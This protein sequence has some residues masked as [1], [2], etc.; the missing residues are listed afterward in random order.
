MRWLGVKGETGPTP[1]LTILVTPRAVASCCDDG[2]HWTVGELLRFDGTSAIAVASITGAERVVDE[3]G[4][5]RL[6][7]FPA[8]YEHRLGLVLGRAVAHEIG[9][10][11]L[12]TN[13]HAQY[14]LMRANIDAR[15]FADLRADSFRLDP[16]ADAYL[17][18]LANRGAL[19]AGPGREAFSYSTQ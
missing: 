2:P 9:H 11:V 14:G 16:A 10:Y 19:F 17:A 8:F 1:A 7:D 3:T 12:Q 15:E 6:V 13:T 18:V 5:F 4:L